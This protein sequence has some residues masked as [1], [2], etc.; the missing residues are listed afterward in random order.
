MGKTPG[1][2]GVLVEQ[3]GSGLGQ[4]PV[5]VRSG[6]HQA[7]AQ[8]GFVVLV[9][10]VG[11]Q[12]H[13][14]RLEVADRQAGLALQQ[15]DQ[16]AA[17]DPVQAHVGVVVGHED[18]PVVDPQ[19]AGHPRDLVQPFGTLDHPASIADP[20]Q[21]ADRDDQDPHLGA[22]A[23]GAQDRAPAADGLV[24]G[25]GGHHQDPA[26]FEELASGLHGQTSFV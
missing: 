15:G 17:G 19:E 22:Q 25:M 2:G 1:V 21:V 20:L 11:R 24:I 13:D 18:L 14:V 7:R 9:V 10:G 12:E 4:G 5:V 23:G 26:A 3:D 8:H 6:G 16:V